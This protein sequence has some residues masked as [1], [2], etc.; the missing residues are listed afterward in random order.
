MENATAL[1]VWEKKTNYFEHYP[2]YMKTNRTE[3]TAQPI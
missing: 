1:I 2:T 3:S